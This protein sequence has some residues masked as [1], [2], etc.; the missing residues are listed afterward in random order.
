MM[1]LFPP[2]SCNGKKD[3]KQ[4]QAAKF[5]LPPI[6]QENP[7][8]CMK[9]ML[10]KAELRQFQPSST[11]GD[12]NKSI[13]ACLELKWKSAYQQEIYVQSN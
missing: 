10:E 3:L 2:L 4:R 11:V 12:K 13:Q 8:E 9:L 1:I 7:L 5:S 6:I